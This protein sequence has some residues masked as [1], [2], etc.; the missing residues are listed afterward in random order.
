MKNKIVFL[1]LLMIFFSVAV[2]AQIQVEN[3]TIDFDLVPEQVSEDT[4]LPIEK[5]V[6]ADL[7]EVDRVNENRYIV[8]HNNNYFILQRDRKLVRSNLSNQ[9]L[10]NSPIVLNQHFLVPV[11]FLEGFLNFNIRVEKGLTL[12]DRIDRDDQEK[13]ADNLRLRVYLNDDEFERDEELKVSIEIMNT[14]RDDINLRFNSAQ[15]YNIY[16]KSLSGRILYS[17]NEGKMFSQALQNI[18]IE[19]QN[20]LSFEEKIGLS[21]FRKGNYI[22][23]IEIVADNYEFE[24]LKKE[25]EIED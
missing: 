23:E 18:E 3:K 16:I 4:Y 2:S 14:G 9:T 24:M 11:E 13:V 12:P 5:L 19:G 8:L 22:V 1:T 7:F 21:Q 17:W 6:N 25:F 20:S 15:K 10:I